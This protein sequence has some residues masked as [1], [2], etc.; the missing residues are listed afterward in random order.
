MAPP[1]TKRT[2]LKTIRLTPE[3]SPPSAT[4][5]RPWDCRSRRSSASSA[6]AAAISV[7]RGIFGTETASTRSRGFNN[8]RQLQRVAEVSGHGELDHELGAT[9][10]ELREL[11]H[12]LIDSLGSGSG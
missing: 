9:I 2:I 4:R 7:P 10:E 6:S 12:A 11:H 5:P 3:S 8:L 1:P